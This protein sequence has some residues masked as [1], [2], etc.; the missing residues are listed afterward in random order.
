ML[1]VTNGDST[2]LGLERAGV[3]GDFVSWPDVLHE[4]PT[5]A[6]LSPDEWRRVRVQF[7]ASRGYGSE[8][9][10]AQRYAADDEAMERWREH[11][12]VVLW[13]EHDLYDQLILI[14][15]LD[16]I[17]RLSNRDATRFSLIQA[18]TYLG[19]MPPEQLA[20]LFPAR[21]PITE[22]QLQLGSRAWQAYCATEPLPLQHL[23][24]EDTS[25][26][27]FLHG[28]L[29]RHF[30]DYPSSSNGLSR[31]E[32]QLL[33]VLAEGARTLPEAFGACSRRE[34]RVFMGDSTFLSIAKSLASAA[35]PLIDGDLAGA[36]R[37]LPDGDVLLTSTGRDVRDG[38]ADHIDLNGI[39]RWAGGVHL[40]PQRCYR[41]NG[42]D[43]TLTR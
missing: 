43:L 9:E 27:P 7:L 18:S 16:W 8:A 2:R 23:A 24:A 20:R 28:A 33:D 38:R 19:P 21:V 41:W 37:E 6:G 12:E 3:P 31:S 17:T 32:A 29:H 34:E 1:H 11:D 14:R 42:R 25:A 39:D 36:I 30:E 35:H 22:E 15:H 5:P 26:L 40:T 13:F 10:I 4:G